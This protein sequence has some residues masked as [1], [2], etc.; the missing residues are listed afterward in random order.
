MVSM[1]PATARCMDPLCL[2]AKAALG[3]CA[4]ARQALG[5]TMDGRQKPE[6]EGEAGQ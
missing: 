4:W 6:A 3:Q 2:K 5:G 1:H